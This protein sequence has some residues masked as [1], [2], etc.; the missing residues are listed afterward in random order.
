MGAYQFGDAR[1]KDYKDAT[2]EEFSREEF[3]ANDELQD[4]IFEWHIEDYTTRIKEDGLDKHI[5]TK[6]K[7]VPVT[8]T[9]LLAVAHLGG[10]SGMTKFLKTQ[11]KYNP[12]DKNKTSLLD[13]LE[14]FSTLDKSKKDTLLQNTEV[15]FVDRILNPENYIKPKEQ[16][17]SEGRSFIETHR[18]SSRDNWAFPTV[19]IEDN[20]YIDLMDRYKGD[21]NAVFDHNKKTGDILRFPSDEEAQNF[22]MNYKDIPSAQKFNE[23]YTPD[24]S[25][26]EE[27]DR[28]NREKIQRKI[29][30]TAHT[31]RPHVD[32]LIK[33]GELPQEQFKSFMSDA[34]KAKVGDAVVDKAKDLGM[35]PNFLD[36]IDAS[37]EIKG[38]DDFSVRAGDFEYEENPFNRRIQKTFG[39]PE[40]I[41]GSVGI[42]Q[43][44]YRDD[45]YVGGKLVFPLGKP[46]K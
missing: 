25:K 23:Y 43:S 8:H 16:I 32:R 5:G 31:I 35:Y 30:D 40:G 18:M 44:K 39:E 29:Y 27:E 12:K 13:Y 2:G 37:A 21:I 1:L 3:L 26:F 28:T 4:K 20:K 7:G 6:I 24:Y 19:V 36:E 45:T 34:V 15:P 17:D 38:K 41:H 9:G 14:K 22:S 11:G 33:T 46:K 10:Y 42:D